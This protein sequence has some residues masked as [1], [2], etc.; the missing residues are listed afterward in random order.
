MH[1]G[2]VRSPSLRPE[3]LPVV[4]SAALLEDIQ[5]FRNYIQ[6]ERGLAAN[7]L[8]AYTRDLD[9]FARSGR[10]DQGRSAAG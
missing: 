2:W 8:L 4:A 10:V 6:A 9:R 1:F 3:G 5:A 7:T